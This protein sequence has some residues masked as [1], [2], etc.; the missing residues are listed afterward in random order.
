MC[1]TATNPQGFYPTTSLYSR[2]SLRL[3]ESS[4]LCYICTTLLQATK[5]AAVSRP[6]LHGRDIDFGITLTPLPSAHPVSDND[7][8]RAIPTTTTIGAFART[9]ST[10]LHEFRCR[11]YHHIPIKPQHKS[12]RCSNLPHPP[13]TTPTSCIR[14]RTQHVS[15]AVQRTPAAGYALWS[16]PDT[17][18]RHGRD[19]RC[20]RWNGL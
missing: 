2:H 14:S 20:S 6:V 8:L 12:A 16:T 1:P 4:R 19:R 10:W 5:V 9:H 15:D 13:F 3:F 7:G 17:S 18:G 11:K